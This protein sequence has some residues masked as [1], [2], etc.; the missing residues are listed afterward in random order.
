MQG[1]VGGSQ[2]PIKIVFS[3]TGG[4][5]LQVRH[6]TAAAGA[7]VGRGRVAGCKHGFSLAALAV[8][9]ASRV[10]LRWSHRVCRNLGGA[11][12][13]ASNGGRGRVG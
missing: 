8:R 13:W 4:F 11:Q 2:N 6:V 1:A 5:V 10:V 7:E 3:L 9:S 12:Q